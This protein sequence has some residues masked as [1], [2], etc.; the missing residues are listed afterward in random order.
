MLLLGEKVSATDAADWGMIHQAV[1]A[2]E[3]DDAAKELVGRLASGPTA[4]I[5]LAKQALSFG[6]HATLS[7]ALT[8][9]LF[10]LELSCRTG[11]FKEGLEAFRQRR[12]PKFHGR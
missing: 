7:Q 12:T 9:E 2:P 4:A 6:Q 5:A 10:N 8:Q 1:N 11:D 3:L